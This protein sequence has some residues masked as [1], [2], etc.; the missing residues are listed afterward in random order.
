MRIVQT[1]FMI[2]AALVASAGVAATL[3]DLMAADRAFDRLAQEEGVRNAF[4]AYVGEDPAMLS[5]GVPPITGDE[6]VR[7]FLGRWPDGMS[8]TWEPKG[9]RIAASGDLGYTWGVF[10]SRGEDADGI[11]VV[12][13]GKYVTVWALQKDGSWKWVVDIGNDSPSPAP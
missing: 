2:A 8:L 4:L 5:H 13:H 10:E 9:G 7:D 6:S 12:R 3:D 1:V 11:E